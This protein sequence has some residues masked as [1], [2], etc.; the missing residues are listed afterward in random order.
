MT[1]KRVNLLMIVLSAVLAVGCVG[2]VIGGDRLLKKES[3][4]IV[5]RRLDNAVLDKEQLALA[6]AKQ[7]LQNYADLQQIAKQVVPQ[8]KDQALTVRQIIA[9]ADKSGVKIGSIGFPGSSL[10]NKAAASTGTTSGDTK[11]T[12]SAISQAKP[13]TGVNGLLALDVVVSSD[14]THPCT[15]DQFIAFL[16]SLETNRRTA[17]VSQLS[18]QPDSRDPSRLNFNLTLRV[19]IK[20]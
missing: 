3:D 4:T 18:I 19:Y 17:Q 2:A 11:S 20:P 9:L 5:Q 1:P 7:D 13:V 8:E 14:N 16:N 12:S 10:G 6:Q 15:Y